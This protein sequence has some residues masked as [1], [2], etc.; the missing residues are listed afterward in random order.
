MLNI[1]VPF[2]SDRFPYYANHENQKGWRGSIRHNLALNDCFIKLDRKIGAKGHDW[3]I[4]PNYEDMFDHGSFLRRRYR[5]KNGIRKEKSSNARP[6][7]DVLG[8]PQFGYGSAL[9]NCHPV[10][11]ANL[12]TISQSTEPKDFTTTSH[13]QPYSHSTDN[14]HNTWNQSYSPINISVKFEEP[15]SPPSLHEMSQSSSDC[16]SSPESIQQ[17]TLPDNHHH[18]TFPSQRMNQYWQTNLYPEQPQYS[19][20]HYYPPPPYPMYMWRNYNTGQLSHVNTGNQQYLQ[21]QNIWT[22]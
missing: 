3:G 4:D 19:A 10:F 7:P 6:S 21:Q 17:T 18:V 8:N 9:D 13:I 2:I 1:S 11:G 15:V 16:T 14:A 5:F 12:S 22:V 20:E